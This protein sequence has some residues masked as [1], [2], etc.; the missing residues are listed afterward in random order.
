MVADGMAPC[1]A[2]LSTPMLS[3]HDVLIVWDRKVL[4]FHEEK[5]SITRIVKERFHRFSILVADGMAPC[6][7]GSSAPM[8]FDYA[9]RE[10]LASLPWIEFQLPVLQS[11]I[12]QGQYHGC[13]WHGSLCRRVI[14]THDV[15]YTK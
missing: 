4:V 9:N 2:G 1:V 3:T 5:I 11:K 10:A 14:S 8:M 13:W 6:V 15:D 7:A 12:S